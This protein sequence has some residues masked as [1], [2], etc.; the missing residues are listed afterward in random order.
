MEELDKT[1]PELMMRYRAASFFI[2]QFAPEISMGMMTT[3]EVYDVGE[4]KKTVHED[5]KTK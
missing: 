5:W 3:E 1:M 4:A 2:N